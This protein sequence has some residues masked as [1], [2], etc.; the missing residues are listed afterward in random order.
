MNKPI[1][2]VLFTRKYNFFEKCFQKIFNKF[3]KIILIF[4]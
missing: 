3:I 1:N 2:I 4:I